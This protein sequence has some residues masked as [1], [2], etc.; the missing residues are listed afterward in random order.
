[1]E[2]KKIVFF[3]TLIFGISVIASGF[4]RYFIEGNGGEAGLWFG[5]VMGGLALLAACLQRGGTKIARC[6]EWIALT[7]ALF[8]GGWFGYENFGKGKRELRMYLMIFLALAEL[9]VLLWY[10]LRKRE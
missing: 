4:Y 5:V 7:I 2:S 10:W 1:M 9:L 3:V 6:G 8:V